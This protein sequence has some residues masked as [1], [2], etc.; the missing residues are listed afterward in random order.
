MA[1]GGKDVYLEVPVKEEAKIE[2]VAAVEATE[3]EPIEEIAVVEET[4]KV[5]EAVEATEEVAVAEEQA[6]EEACSLI[7][8]FTNVFTY[9][10]KLYLLPFN[11]IAEELIAPLL[12]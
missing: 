4:A 7:D 12:F 11:V 8:D 6:A 1:F 9:R 2:A 3:A 10:H 5:A